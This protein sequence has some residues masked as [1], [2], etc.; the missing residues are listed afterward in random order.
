MPKRPRMVICPRCHRTIPEG[1]LAE[2][3]RS[4]KGKLPSYLRGISRA[5]PRASLHEIG[6]SAVGFG[7]FF[8]QYISEM[9][10]RSNLSQE[11]IRSKFEVALKDVGAQY[12]SLKLEPTQA[13]EF[14]EV[15]IDEQRNLIL[16]YSPLSLRTVSEERIEA[17]LL[18]EACHVVTLPDSILRVPDIGGDEMV[19]FMANYLTN[20]DEYLAHVEFVNRFKGDRRYE[21]FRQQQISLFRNFKIMIDSLKVMVNVSIETGQR[22]GQF[23]LLEYLHD[24]TYDA[25]FFYVAKD[26]SFLTWCKKHDLDELYIFIGWTFEDFEHIR[27]LGLPRKETQNKVIPSGV[28]SMSVNPFKLL[29][30]GQIEFAETAKV[31]HEEMMQKGQDTDLVELWE[32]RR[33]LYEK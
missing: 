7:E 21:A 17:I 4:H 16:K 27:S 25:L 9:P 20:Y 28:L 10:A 2:H 26:D 15:F 13:P 18:H 11:Q 3:M 31:L 29:I 8:K 19:A 6:P 32:R 12:R 1:K 22:I 5:K 30:L 24:I 23:K 33:L 14:I